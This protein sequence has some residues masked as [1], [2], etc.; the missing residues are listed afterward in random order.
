MTI[1]KFMYMLGEESLYFPNIHSFNDKYE[2]SLSEKSKEEVRKTNLFDESTPIKQDKPFCVMKEHM[3]TYSRN[4]KDS[5]MFNL[6]SFKTL[7]EDFSN[8]IMFCNCWFLKETESHSMWAEY[9]DKSPTSIAIVTTVGDLIESLEDLEYQIHIGN[10][11]YKNYQTDD[12]EGY[13]N[14]P[15][16][17]LTKPDTV[18]ELFYAPIMHKRDIYDDEHEVRAIIS[19]ESICENHADRVYTSK[20]PFYSDKLFEKDF[21]FFD[22]DRKT[23]LMK[24]IPPEGI[25]VRTN[26]NQLIQ[27]VVISPYAK[28]FFKEQ[29]KKLLEKHNMNPDIVEKSKINY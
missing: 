5:T 8:H 11:K 20:I 1:D 13:E 3:E 17:N 16:K 18:L 19:F 15:S 23:N 21:L 9:G 2:G 12:I 22:P 7:I 4:D 14:F 6:H 28:K 27:K 24:D 29:L 26:I 25:P 10:V